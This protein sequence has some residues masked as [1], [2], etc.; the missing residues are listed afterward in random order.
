M[1]CNRR[2]MDP[3]VKATAKRRI[4]KSFYFLN[5]KKKKRRTE[6]IQP[7]VNCTFLTFEHMKIRKNTNTQ[8]VD[9]KNQHLFNELFKFWKPNRQSALFEM[10]YA[11]KIL[12]KNFHKNAECNDF[13]EIFFS[14][15]LEN[16]RFIWKF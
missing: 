15:F 12:Y 14:S 13:I 16:W 9:R 7:S 8:Y 6:T 3:N 10:Q 2:M 1:G 5:E 4:K 11:L